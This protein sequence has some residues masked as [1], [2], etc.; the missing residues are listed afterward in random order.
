MFVASEI[1]VCEHGT[2]FLDQRGELRKAFGVHVSP[3]PTEVRPATTAEVRAFW[4]QRMHVRRELTAYYSRP[5]LDSG[6]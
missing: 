2:G 5:N 6:D 3:P 4:E 1:I